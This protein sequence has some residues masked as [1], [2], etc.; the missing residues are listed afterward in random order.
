MICDV[1][2]IADEE[3]HFSGLDLFLCDAGTSNKDS[4]FLK[5]W[6]ASTTTLKLSVDS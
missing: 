1:E 6:K 3:I 5:F 4:T 2:A